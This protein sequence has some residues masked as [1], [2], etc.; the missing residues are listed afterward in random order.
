MTDSAQKFDLSAM[1]SDLL[2]FMVWDFCSL[3]IIIFKGAILFL[4]ILM[5]MVR[6]SLFNALYAQE[7]VHT[8]CVCG[9]ALGR[10]VSFFKGKV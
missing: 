2:Q 1:L 7:K 5:I 10:F 3:I 4:I 6:F 8:F 9:I